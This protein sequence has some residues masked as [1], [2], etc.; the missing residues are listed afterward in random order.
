MLEFVSTHATRRSA[1]DL[2]RRNKR[3]LRDIDLAELAHLLLAFLLLLQK[4]ALSRDVAAVAFCGD[5]LAQR[6]DSFAGK[7]LCGVR[8]KLGG[9]LRSGVKQ[10]YSD[11]ATIDVVIEYNVRCDLGTLQNIAA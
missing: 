4:F 2:K 5:V 8:Q 9:Q 10:F 1:I 6:V 11:D 3:L 7:Y